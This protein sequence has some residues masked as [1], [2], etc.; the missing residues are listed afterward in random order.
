MKPIVA[1]LHYYC[2]HGEIVLLFH[3][4]WGPSMW[5]G[6]LECNPYTTLGVNPTNWTISS[7]FHIKHYKLPPP[8]YTT[9]K[10]SMARHSHVLIYHGPVSQP[11]FWELLHLLSLQCKNQKTSLEM[12]GQLL[13]WVTRADVMLRFCFGGST[14]LLSPFRL[15]KCLGQ[16]SSDSARGLPTATAL[17]NHTM[18]QLK[19]DS[20]PFPISNNKNKKHVGLRNSFQ[21]SC[22]FL[23]VFSSH[24]T[25]PSPSMSSNWASQT[26]KRPRVFLRRSTQSQRRGATTPTTGTGDSDL[27]REKIVVEPTQIEKK[28][29]GSALRCTKMYNYVHSLEHLGSFIS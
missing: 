27:D 9:W 7:A 8:R 14:H 23:L 6:S 5:H 22:V 11:T 19:L 15:L 13:C 16:K 18:L 3:P 28:K 26:H 21:S 24:E 25:F 2:W 12:K 17:V 10:G 4:T 1:E 29:S 20:H